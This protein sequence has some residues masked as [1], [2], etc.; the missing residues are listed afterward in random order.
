MQAYSVANCKYNWYNAMQIAMPNHH[1]LYMALTSL[2]VPLMI[3]GTVKSYADFVSDAIN[4]MGARA[5]NYANP[6]SEYG[7]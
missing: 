2:N 5:N 1:Y 7:V 6:P 4:G 3:A